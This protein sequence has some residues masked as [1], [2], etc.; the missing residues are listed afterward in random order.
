[1]KNT[2]LASSLIAVLISY[3]AAQDNDR[4]PQASLDGERNIPVPARATVSDNLSRPTLTP[5]DYCKPC[6][7]YAG[8]FD[9]T[10]SDANGLTNEFD[11]IVSTGAA[12]YTPFI[13][14]KGKTWTV[15]GLFTNNGIVYG[16]QVLDP[17][18]IPY[19][20]RKG[21]PKDGGNGGK[22]VCHGR[23]LG[24]LTLSQEDADELF[25]Y[26]TQ[27]RHIK[28]CHLPAG[29]YWL[30]VVPYCTNKN[31]H[32]CVDWRMFVMND[33]GAMANRYGP[34]EP[35]NNSFFN[36]A[37]FGAVWEPSSREQ[38]SARFSVGVEGTAK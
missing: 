29:K 7:F 1:V 5:P 31:D 22:L 37:F 32:N 21:I 9:S 34:L 24:T 12:V 4:F 11:L 13:V 15:T 18:V 2:L 27:V 25:I 19:E 28:G 3:A 17:K 16:T 33:D 38:S 10:A 26:A 20:I 6:L 14:P 8:D 36:S 30:S 35:A 23:K